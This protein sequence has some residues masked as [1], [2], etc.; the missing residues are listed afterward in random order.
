MLG[1]LRTSGGE[2]KLLD[3]SEAH[4]EQHFTKALE[5]SKDVLGYSDA[6]P[7]SH[8]TGCWDVVCWIVSMCVLNCISQRRWNI[9]RMCWVI[10]TLFLNRILQGV[11]M[12]FVGL[13]QCVS[14]TAFHKGVGIFQGC[15]GLFW[16]SSWIAFYRVLGC[17]L[18]DC[19]N[20]CPELHF[21]K[22]LEYSKDVL[23]YS[24]TLPESHFTGCWDV[25][26]WIVSMCVLNCI[27]QRRWN[28]PRMCWVIL[29]LFLNRILQGVGMLFVGL[30]Q[31]VSWTAF[32]RALE[33]SNDS[34]QS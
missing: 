19:F 23:G 22:A 7:E 34:R 27:S 8:F 9:P 20:V 14:W 31:R 33:Y 17:C 12:L 30:F 1:N 16:R 2:K 18:L 28:I 15:V 32:H 6:L 10:L 13:F 26:C 21:T 24:D 29:T 3:Y 5:Y 25:V 11:G 4:P